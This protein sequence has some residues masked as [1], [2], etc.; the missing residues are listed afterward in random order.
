MLVKQ[1]INAKAVRFPKKNISQ[2]EYHAYG[3]KK[4][5]RNEKNERRRNSHDYLYSATDQRGVLHT[6]MRN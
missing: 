5:K 6:C 1:N 3:K 2:M 4:K